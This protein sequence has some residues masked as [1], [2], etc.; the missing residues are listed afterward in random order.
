MTRLTQ[1]AIAAAAV[2]VVAIVGYNLLPRN[3]SSIGGQPTPIP[4]PTA[5][6]IAAP[7]GSVPHPI[8]AGR[9]EAGAPLQATIGFT[10]PA[11]WQS[12]VGG[13]NF[14]AVERLDPTTGGLYFSFLGNV[15]AD[16]CH[17]ATALAS[18]SL[19][20]S[21]AD[22]VTALTHLAGVTATTPVD[23]TIAGYAAKS[24]TLTPAVDPLTC[25]GGVVSVW[26][27]P[28]GGTAV[29]NPG[30]DMRLWI[31]TVGNH[32]L[33][34]EADDYTRQTAAMRADVQAV[35]DSVTIAP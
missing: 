13:P 16:P 4:S 11:G 12:N 23:A 20:P 19:G 10:V 21:V 35:L 22:L 30:Q 2:L 29:L 14:L 3:S 26:R 5:T 27:L 24:L 18:P 8:A 1:F 6:P 25:A 7:Q 9:Y 17:S 28:L 31:V 33:V 34:I 32:R 15:F